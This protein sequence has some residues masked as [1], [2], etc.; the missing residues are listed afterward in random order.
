MINMMIPYAGVLIGIFL[1]VIRILQMLVEDIRKLCQ[2]Q[3]GG[4][5]HE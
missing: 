4:D 2:S 1:M 3:R 5:G